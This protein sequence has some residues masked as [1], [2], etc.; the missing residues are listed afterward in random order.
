MRA[1]SCELLLECVLCQKQSLGASTQETAAEAE[2][3]ESLLAEIWKVL[4]S[5]WGLA[6]G[7]CQVRHWPLCLQ[8]PCLSVSAFEA[9]RHLQSM[10]NQTSKL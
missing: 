4:C 7:H 2:R 10:T 5:G 1:T 3:Y 9:S 6:A 8:S